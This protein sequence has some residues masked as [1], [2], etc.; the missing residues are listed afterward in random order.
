MF[1]AT[2]VEIDMKKSVIPDVEI[3]FE[4][5]SDQNKDRAIVEAIE[6]LKQD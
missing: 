1:I 2:E 3:P 6:W 5:E 4:V